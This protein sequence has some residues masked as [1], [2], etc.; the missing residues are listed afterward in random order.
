MTVTA[1][2][3]AGMAPPA[4]EPLQR[5]HFCGGRRSGGLDLY[6]TVMYGKHGLSRVER[7]LIAVVVSA[8]N[9]CQY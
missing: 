9:Q 1:A 6:R 2:A 5:C 4:D 3:A 7:E 8:V